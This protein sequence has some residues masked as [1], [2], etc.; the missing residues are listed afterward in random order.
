MRKR[1]KFN[2]LISTTLVVFLS[3]TVAQA[4]I[5]LETLGQK[6]LG[7][8]G[9]HT[10]LI[11]TFDNRA[12]IY[13]TDSQEMLGMLSLGLNANAVEIDKEQGVIHVAEN[14]FSRLARGER[15]DV[16][17]T[18]EIKT[19]SAVS[20][21]IIPPKHSSGSPMRH[22]SGV[23]DDGRFMLVNNITPAQSISVVNLK[24]GEFVG[25]IPTP[26]CGLVY[27]L[28]GLSFMQLCGDGTAQHISLT[29]SGTEVTRT[30]S[31]KFFD[32]ENDPLMEKPVST[33]TGWVF[34][35][36]KGKVYRVSHDGEFKV[37]A[38]FTITD[39]DGAWRVGGIQ[40]LSYHRG[41][42]L[43]LA[44]MHEGGEDTHKDHGTQVWIYDL[45]S[46]QQVH[47]FVLDN[48]ASA[49][50]V[51]QDQDPR[52]YAAFVATSQVDIYDLRKNKLVGSLTGISTPTIL[53]NL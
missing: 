2:A 17:T 38:L 49:I 20:E 12:V 4:D 33:D 27:P 1:M 45:G 42:N 8:L 21:V 40:P 53:Q 30:R 26:G 44:L 25:E 3:G 52:M 13:D 29:D 28:A 6:T 18:Y 7:E 9:D 22:Y 10:L 16:V 39:E 43:L 50:Q 11:N 47:R 46:Q 35:T 5:A 14:Y 31:E 19:L 15:T 23:L 37:E 36:F 48:P 32:L 51:S 24:E 34:N 41:S